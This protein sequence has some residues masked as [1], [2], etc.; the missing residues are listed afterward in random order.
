MRYPIYHR[1]QEDKLKDA[2]KLRR[3]LILAGPRQCGKTTLTTLFS[4]PDTV[5][6]TL[7]DITLL[8]AAKSDPLGFVYHGDGLM[9]IDEVQRAPELLL[10]VKLNVDLNQNPGRFLLTGSANIQSL[11]GVTESL[12]GRVRKIRLRPLAQGEIYGKAPRFISNAYLGKFIPFAHKKTN[13]HLV[14]NKDSYLSDAFSGGYPEALRLD[15][16]KD[17]RQW[18]KDYVGALIERDL[19]DI[20]NIKRKDHMLKLLEVLAAWSS[21][22]M[23]ISSIGSHL[24]L[25]R[26][27]IESYINALEALYLVERIRPWHKTD[28]DRISKQD[29][30]FMTDTGL[31][32]SILGWKFENIRLNGELNGKLLETFVFNQLAAILDA[33]QENYQLYHYRDRE[34]R[35]ID[36]IIENDDDN[37]LGIEVKAGSVVT[38]DSFKHLKWFNNN[39]AKKRKFTGIVLYT[40]ENVVS[41]GENMWAVPINSLWA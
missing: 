34:K 25:S 2:L 10:A 17:K 7:D 35:E 37:L 14:Y 9:I 41:F 31:M 5:Y 18:Y 36:F 38:I 20:I 1:W 11:P 28:Y 27:T 4:T 3:V 15:T 13:P 6:R 30:L 21:K 22:F 33:E 26:P 23:D 29:K 12:A 39:L 19:K 8:D 24:S 32:V 16:E 40:G